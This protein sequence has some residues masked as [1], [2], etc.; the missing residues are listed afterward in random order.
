MHC[1]I[2]NLRKN[3]ENFNLNV[4]LCIEK[5]KIFSLIGPSGCGKTTLLR[6]I[7]RLEDSDSGK[8][9]LDGIN[10]SQARPENLGIGFVFQDHALFP[11]LSV[12]NNVAYGL[13]VR[14]ISRKERIKKADSLL[15]QMNL[16]GFGNRNV[17]TLSGGEKQKVA[18]ARA[19]ATDPKL[20][21][22]DEPLS[23]VDENQ[24]SY[25]RDEILLRLKEYN[26]TTIWVTHDIDEAFIVADRIAIMN[27]GKIEGI[28]TP[29]E[30][31]NFPQNDFIARFLDCGSLIPSELNQDG[32]L[33]TPIGFF[34]SST[35]PFVEKAVSGFLF[36]RHFEIY[37]SNEF[38]V[39]K[40]S[41]NIFK[42]T[43]LKRFYIRGKWRC[44]FESSGIKLVIVIQEENNIAIGETVFIQI[45]PQDCHFLFKE[46]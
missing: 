14:N 1:E 15:V 35:I 37:K 21:L 36:F 6:L 19:L 44:E 25:V 5:G 27:N 16:S 43:C 9:F 33:S 34:K 41:Q 20:V 29:Y 18:L 8:I 42:A 26:V 7:S 39:K 4:N 12:R 3:Y 24:R 32:I 10:V 13:A 45:N 46:S 38:Q 2:Q 23:A 40:I 17:S 28:G 22:L 11:H 31:W 30:L